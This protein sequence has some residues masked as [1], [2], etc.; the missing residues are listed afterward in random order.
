MITGSGVM[1]I[2]F[3]KELTRNPENGNTPV[4]ISGDWNE[5]GLPNLA[6]TFL[7]KCYGILQNAR[8]TAFTVSELLRGNQLAGGG[9]KFTP[10]PATQIRV[11]YQ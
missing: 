10:L 5:Q 2:S 8:I 1:T 9:G 4:Q 3:Y 6:R 7:I 11:K